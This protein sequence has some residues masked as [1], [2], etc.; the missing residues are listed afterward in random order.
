MNAPFIFRWLRMAVLATTLG[1]ALLQADE[2]PAWRYTVKPGDN[3][4]NIAARYFSRA[5]QWPKVQ[6]ANN[7][8]DPNRILPGTVLRISPELLH[9]TP[10]EALLESVSGS[11]RWRSAGS[12]MSCW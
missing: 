6:K 4:I 3:L 9:K 5:D 7:I 11:V 1:S 2:A 10:G 8:A 12:G